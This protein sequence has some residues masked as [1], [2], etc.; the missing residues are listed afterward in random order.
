M[1]AVVD[2]YR[3]QGDGMRHDLA[4]RLFE[5]YVPQLQDLLA[6]FGLPCEGRILAAR[7]AEDLGLPVSALAP[8]EDIFITFLDRSWRV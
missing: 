8:W 5:N 1:Q 7:M 3:V 4:I 6:N 2:E